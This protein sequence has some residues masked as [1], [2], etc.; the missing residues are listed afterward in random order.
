MLETVREFAAERL[1]DL[2]CAGCRPRCPCCSILEP[3]RATWLDLRAGRTSHSLDLLELEHD[4]FRA[5]LD[6]Y[7]R[8]E[9]AAALRL[10]NRLTGVLVCAR[11]L[12]RGQAAPP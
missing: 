12:L 6:W 2:A 5:A 9:P 3:S 4:N 11:A 1:A 7:G 10:A 8:E